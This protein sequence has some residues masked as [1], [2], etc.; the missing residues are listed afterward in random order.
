ML[1][2]QIS[3][4]KQFNKQLNLADTSGIQMGRLVLAGN[5]R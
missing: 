2:T 5:K 3:Y 1:H 4:I